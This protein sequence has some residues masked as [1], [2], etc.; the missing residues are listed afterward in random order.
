M[1]NVLGVRLIKVLPCCCPSSVHPSSRLAIPP[2]TVHPSSRPAVLPCCDDVRNLFKRAGH[3][4]LMAK[5]VQDAISVLE[6]MLKVFT[7]DRDLTPADSKVLNG[8][9]DKLKMSR[10]IIEGILNNAIYDV[11]E[12][13]RLLTDLKRELN[14]MVRTLNWLDSASDWEELTKGK[15]GGVVQN[16]KAAMV[17][18]SRDLKKAFGELKEVSDNMDELGGSL[19]L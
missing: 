9:A 8:C 7:P 1:L 19:G 6:G 11:T 14:V 15:R 3:C 12:Q 17:M 13:V 5:P 10:A 16:A 4:L 2:S 18:S